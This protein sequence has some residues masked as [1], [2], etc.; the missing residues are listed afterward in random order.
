MTTRYKS[1]LGTFAFTYQYQS[2]NVNLSVSLST[3]QANR[4]LL[5]VIYRLA[6]SDDDGSENAYEIIRLLIDQGGA[7][8]HLPV[9]VLLGGQQHRHLPSYLKGKALQEDTPLVAAVRAKD[10]KALQCMVDSYSN[11]LFESKTQR[12]NDPLLRSQPESYFRLLEEKEDGAYISTR[13]H[14]ST[15]R[16]LT[17]YSCRRRSFVGRRSSCD[18]F[19]L[20]LG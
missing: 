4:A 11:A 7:N 15:Q 17:V 12:R 18:C 16:T 2:A 10:A 13:A 20:A 3:L 19:V 5:E 6:D 14:C 1:A 9:S 8:P